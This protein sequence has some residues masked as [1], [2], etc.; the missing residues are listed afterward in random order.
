MI[1]VSHNEL[2]GV[3]AKA[4][5]ALNHPHGE[6]DTIADT[7]VD[8]EMAGLGGVSMFVEALPSLD[9]E[10]QARSPLCDITDGNIL[11]NLHGGSLFCHLPALID[12]AVERLIYFPEVSMAVRDC[13]NRW[14]AFGELLKLAGKGLSVRVCWH[15]SDSPDDIECILNA[16]SRYPDIYL[17]KDLNL[18]ENSMQIELSLTPFTA[19]NNEASPTIAGSVQSAAVNSAWEQ[20][21]SIR[22]NDWELLK[23]YASRLLVED[24]DRS[25]RG[26]GE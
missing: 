8:L 19:S 13:R 16:G 2:V 3:C 9:G 22:L 26:A 20:G 17:Q 25:M 5:D 14:L 24:S 6:S 15:R 21:I 18:A 11:V 10:Q 23:H 4:F 12:V 7:V 1:R